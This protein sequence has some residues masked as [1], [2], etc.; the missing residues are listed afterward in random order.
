VHC[1]EADVVGLARLDGKK[2]AIKIKN[3][4]KEM[5]ILLFDLEKILPI[6]EMKLTTKI[7]PFFYE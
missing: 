4:Y 7:S 2:M 6:A 5:F 1:N 3:K